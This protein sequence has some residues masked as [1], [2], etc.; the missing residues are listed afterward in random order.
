MTPYYLF[1]GGISDICH[2]KTLLLDHEGE[3]IIAERFRN[4]HS[5]FKNKECLA[6]RPLRL[7]QPSFTKISQGRRNYIKIHNLNFPMKRSSKKKQENYIFNEIL[8]YEILL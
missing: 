3:V 5:K 7:W 4:T 6:K 1:L 8:Y 2:G